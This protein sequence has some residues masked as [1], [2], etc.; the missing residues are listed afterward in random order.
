MH[1]RMRIDVCAHKKAYAYAYP[2]I[3]AYIHTYLYI[4]IYTYVYIYI[5]ISVAKK[6]DTGRSSPQ[7]RFRRHRRLQH[8]RIYAYI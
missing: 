3:H 4:H 5:Y 7:T 6:D 2:Y 1:G 8:A